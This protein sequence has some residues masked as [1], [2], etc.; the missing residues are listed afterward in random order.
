MPQYDR[1][2]D[3]SGVPSQPDSHADHGRAA[4]RRVPLPKGS[5]A[6]PTTALRADRPLRLPAERR[7]PRLALE[8]AQFEEKRHSGSLPRSHLLSYRKRERSAPP[9]AERARR[10]RDRCPFD[11]HEDNHS[12]APH[13]GR[14][15]RSG[16]RIERSSDW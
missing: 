6:A 4:A 8:T 2:R 16:M 13:Q 12:D 5:D 1:V 9:G 14:P 3:T 15:V 11:G 10:Q 7:G